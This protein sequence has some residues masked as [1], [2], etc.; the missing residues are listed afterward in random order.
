MRDESPFVRG[1]IWMVDFG[2]A[3]ED[4]E[5]AFRRPAVIVSDDR[6]HHPNLEMV[7][8]VPGTSTIRQVPLHI[9]VD[10]GADVGLPD[11]TAFQVEQVRAVSVARFVERLGRLDAVSRTAIDEVLRTALHL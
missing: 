1:D 7:I 4:P 6:L 5:Q 9:V 11:R 8:V 2:S 10:A 3:P